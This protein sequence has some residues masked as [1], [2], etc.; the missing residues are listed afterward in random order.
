MAKN[1]GKGYEE[2]VQQVMEGLLKIGGEGISNVDLRRNVIL[3]GMTTLADGKKTQHQ[4]D[5][6]WEFDFG[7][8]SYKTVIQAKDWKQKV[9]LPALHTF[10]GHAPKLVEI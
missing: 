9:S 2:L 3:D 4:I 10:L 8:T 1:T 5:I 7:P 6:F